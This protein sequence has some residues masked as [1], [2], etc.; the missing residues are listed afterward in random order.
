MENTFNLLNL[1]GHSASLTNSI[2]KVGIAALLKKGLKYI[3][4][5]NSIFC[6]HYP[7]RQ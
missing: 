1:P 4:K 3:G 7:F 2:Y 6:T 5:P